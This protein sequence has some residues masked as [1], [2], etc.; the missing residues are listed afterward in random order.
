MIQGLKAERVQSELAW[1]PDWAYEDDAEGFA[2]GFESITRT[3]NFADVPTAFTFAAKVVAISERH[4]HYP[5]LNVDGPN[6]FVRLTTP[7]A[8]GLSA[9]D[10]DMAV[11]FDHYYRTVQ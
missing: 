2:R 9:I 1:I 8:G 7:E 11:L 10:I 4:G 6:V 5:E 3:Y